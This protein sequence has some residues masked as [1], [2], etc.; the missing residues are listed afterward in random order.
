M[1]QLAGRL[2]GLPRLNTIAT[3]RP[4]PED[5]RAALARRGFEE[6]KSITRL[7]CTWGES[8]VYVYE[9]AGDGGISV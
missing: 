9:R 5:G 8:D 4:F 6:R 7:V 3:L 2:A 1:S